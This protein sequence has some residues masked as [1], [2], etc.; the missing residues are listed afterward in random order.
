MHGTNSDNLWDMTHS[1]LQF[2]VTNNTTNADADNA[3]GKSC[4]VDAFIPWFSKSQI[5]SGGQELECIEEYARLYS[6]LASAQGNPEQCG[7]W[8]LTQFDSWTPD[9]VVPKVLFLFFLM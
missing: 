9:H 8:S 1:F 5:Y 7:E 4:A 2:D 6:V 3:T